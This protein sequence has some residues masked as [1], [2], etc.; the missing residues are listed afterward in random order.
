MKAVCRALGTGAGYCQ[1]MEFII[2]SKYKKLRASLPRVAGQRW[3]ARRA[4]R[5]GASRLTVSRNSRANAD[6]IFWLIYDDHGAS[7]PGRTPLQTGVHVRFVL[8]RVGAPTLE[9]LSSPFGVVVT[10][11]RAIS[12]Q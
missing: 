7:L 9:V 3:Y 12:I 10:V 6:I 4:L 11:V 5:M 1:I 8:H 2:L